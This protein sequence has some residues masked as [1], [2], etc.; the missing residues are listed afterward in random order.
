M[1]KCQQCEGTNYNEA[2]ADNADS[3][4][5]ACYIC[6]QSPMILAR[7]AQEC[8]EEGYLQMYEESVGGQKANLEETQWR[9]KA[10]THVAKVALHWICILKVSQNG[11]PDAE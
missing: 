11:L 1:R 7:Y 5:I 8:F 3:E 6:S 2:V 9:I 10:A 4:V